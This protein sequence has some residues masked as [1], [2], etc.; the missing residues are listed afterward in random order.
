MRDRLLWA[1][2]AV[3]P[4]TFALATIVLQRAGGVTMFD[5]ELG[6]LGEA[7][8]FSTRDG[9]PLLAGIPF[10]S[11]GYPALLALPVSIL[12]FDPWVIAVGVNVVLL[13]ALGPLLHAM[14][15]R[16]FGLRGIAAAVVAIAGATATSVVFQAPRAWAEVC[17][18]FAFTLWAWLLLRYSQHGPAIGALPFTIAAGGMLAVHRRSSIVV[19]ITLGAVA[20]WSLA[21]LVRRTDEPLRVRARAVPWRS[22][23]LAEVAGVAAAAGALALD[24]YVVDTLYDGTTS[25]SRL[26]KAQNLLS[27]DW[28]PAAI[29]HVWSFLATTFVLAG[30]GCLFLL[31]TVRARR[32][33]VFSTVLLLALAAIAG[34][35]VLFLANGIRADQLVYERYLAATAPVLVMIGAGAVAARMTPVRSWVLASA[36]VL[37][38]SGFVLSVSLESSRLTGNVQKFTTPTLTTF[39]MVVTG[40]GE[41]FTEG[42]HVLP[43][44]AVVLSVVVVVAGAA[45]WRAWLGPAVVVVAGAATVAAGSAGNLKPFT[46]QWEPTGREA[47]RVLADADVEVLQYAPHLRHEVRNVLH[48]R[49]GYPD[50]VL[51]DPPSC[52]VS[53]YTV[54]PPTLEDE[55][56][57][58]VIGV[59]NFPGGVYRIDC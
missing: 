12:P 51:T 31:W 5:D 36:G 25:G 52:D 11:A 8:F 13:A 35:S 18:A 54:G 43:I 59:G 47:A 38:V 55:G 21:P 28:I 37:A 41:P 48:Y 6:F 40:W 10:Y 56:L 32:H 15:R 7:V 3:A 42:I 16:L 27:T 53:P 22:F 23:V 1:S 24:A 44:T 46:D 9:A 49:L 29:G 26:D 39:D 14:A 50:A 20:V 45:S 33:V 4:L 34:T 30:V 2:T 58:P 57:A 19:L 17:I